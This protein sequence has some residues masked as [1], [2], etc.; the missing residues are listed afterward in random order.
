MRGTSVDFNNMRIKQLCNRKVR[1]VSGAFEKR[2]PGQKV[3]AAVHLGW[4]KNK[5]YLS[6]K[7]YS[8]MTLKILHLYLKLYQN[9]YVLR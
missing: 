6:S 7:P 5:C 2:V 8:I 1:D 4:I 9:T 3:K